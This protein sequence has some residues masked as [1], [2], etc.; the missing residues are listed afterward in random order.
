MRSEFQSADC[1]GDVIHLSSNHVDQCIAYTSDADDPN[2]GSMEMLCDDDDNAYIIQ[3]GATPAL[4][5]LGSQRGSVGG[6]LM[7]R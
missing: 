1:S 3:V 6:P 5:A 2:G 7:S 4:V